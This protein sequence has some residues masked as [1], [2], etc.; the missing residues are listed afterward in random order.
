MCA[1]RRAQAATSPT[2]LCCVISE[3]QD[4]MNLNYPV[5]EVFIDLFSDVVSAV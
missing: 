3:C 4:V 5:V 1:C 2:L